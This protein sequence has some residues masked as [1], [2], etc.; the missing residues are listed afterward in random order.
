MS[1]TE[2]PKCLP[3]IATCNMILIICFCALSLNMH[4]MTALSCQPTHFAMK[5]ERR[6][7][8]CVQCS[9]SRKVTTLWTHMH[10]HVAHKYHAAFA[11][12]IANNHMFPD[13]ML[14]HGW[15][16][17]ANKRMW[18][19]DVFT[20]N[21]CVNWDG[22]NALAHNAPMVNP[23]QSMMGCASFGLNA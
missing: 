6:W 21:S 13:G 5:F 19:T 9:L 14:W 10:K 18:W 7:G 4:N 11:H 8:C 1:K 23:K 22:M 2:L 15:C 12:I 20:A 16:L 3:A 17:L